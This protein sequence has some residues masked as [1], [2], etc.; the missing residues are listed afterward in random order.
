MPP[1]L[2]EFERAVG[3]AIAGAVSSVAER[4]FFASVDRCDRPDLDDFE[5]EWLVASIRFEDG[6]VCGSLACSLPADLSLRLFDAFSGRD[7]A[8]PLPPR[9]QVDDVIGEFSN[10]VCGAWLSRCDTHRVF[11]LGQPVVTRVSRPDQ[12]ESRRE[13]LAVNNRPV[14]IDWDI[15]TV[16]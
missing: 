6:P 14:A 7:P 16:R 5:T 4:C 2:T 9:H 12:G 1:Q 13:W 3:G 15:A 8:M 11:R 10:M